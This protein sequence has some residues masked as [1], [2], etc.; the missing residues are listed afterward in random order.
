MTDLARLA[1]DK[2]IVWTALPLDVEHTAQVLKQASVDCKVIAGLESLEHV[3][4]EQPS[5]VIVAAELLNEEVIAKFKAISAKQKPWSELA[6]VI[7]AGETGSQFY[8][9]IMRE[10]YEAFHQVIFLSRPVFIDTFVGVIQGVL[11]EHRRHYDVRA[12]LERNEQELTSRK[13]AEQSLRL[14]N[15]QLSASEAKYR[16]LLDTANEGILT[17]DNQGRI[18][19]ANRRMIEMI[20]YL[21][22]ELQGKLLQ[23]IVIKSD[24]KVAIEAWINDKRSGIGQE[25][26]DFS[27][28]DGSRLVGIVSHSPIASD[29]GKLSGFFVMVTDITSRREIEQRFRQLTEKSHAELEAAKQEAEAANRAKSAFLANLSHEIRTPICAM[30]GFSELLNDPHLTVDDRISYGNIITRNGAQLV[31]LIDD[32]LDLSKIEA[33]FLQIENIKTSLLNLLADIKSS[34]SIKASEKGIKLSIDAA[35][36]IPETIITDPIRLRQILLNLIGNAV[37][38]TEKGSV[39]VTVTYC[40]PDLSKPGELKFVVDDTGCGIS[41]TGKDKLFIPFSQVDTTPTRKFGGTGLGLALSRRLARSLGGDVVLAESS[42]GKGSRFVARIGA[43]VPDDELKPKGVQTKKF[44]LGDIAEIDKKPLTSLRVLLA[45]DAVDSQLLITQFLKIAGARVDVVGDGAAAITKALSETYDVVLMDVQM[46]ILDGYSATEA[47]RSR[48][49]AR[50]IIALTAHA[51][52][53]EKEK[54][55]R[56]GCDYHLVKPVDRQNLVDTVAR[57][58]GRQVSF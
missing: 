36:P 19:Y 23:D 43:S 58:S 26:Y 51:M 29:S 15:Q 34:L 12:L 18:E 38:F 4:E 57:F 47:L 40:W 2:A 55:L 14:K 8:G 27:K 20:G 41:E 28:K 52:V 54:S 1:K 9:T 33:G 10:I 24:D 22:A 37:K 25:E 7:M 11:L 31:A 53:G 42:S 5:V 17:L 49:Y 48:G 35:G 16:R 3:L 21:P 13:I 56:A 44:V 50:P 30:V 32:I 6:L 39:T 45:E 46:P